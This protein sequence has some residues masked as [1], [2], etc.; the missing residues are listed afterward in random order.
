[1][2]RLI[3]YR[4]FE[5]PSLRHPI[6]KASSLP[7]KRHWVIDWRL[8]HSKLIL[9]GI[10]AI[11]PTLACAGTIGG[12]PHGGMSS[13]AASPRMMGM[14]AGPGQHGPGPTGSSAAPGQSGQGGY[15]Y[16]PRD[17]SVVDAYQPWPESEMRRFQKPRWEPYAGN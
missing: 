12:G 15:Y 3:A 14:Q 8:G 5:S 1:M 13:G 7:R 6:H 4:G 16:G 17:G 2:L 10:V 9:T 11:L